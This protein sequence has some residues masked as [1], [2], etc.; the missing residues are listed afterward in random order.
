MLS[1]GLSP[2]VC[3]NSVEI[4]LSTHC[5]PQEEL[6]QQHKWILKYKGLE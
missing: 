6:R 2:L 5:L 1:T 3:V 4:T